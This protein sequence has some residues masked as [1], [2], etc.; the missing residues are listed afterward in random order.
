MC[1]HERRQKEMRFHEIVAEKKTQRV[2][3]VYHGTSSKNVRNILKLG[4]VANPKNKTYDGGLESMGG[5]YSTASKTYALDMGAVA[6]EKND[7]EHIALV[8]MQFVTGS[9]G[10]DEDMVG[11]ILKSTLYS[12]EV[13][14]VLD[15]NL[16]LSSWSNSAPRT[17]KMKASG[18]AQDA[19]HKFTDNNLGQVNK[20]TEEYLKEYIFAVLTDGA[21]IYSSDPTK[22][23]ELFSPFSVTKFGHRD[24][25]L[26]ALDSM[27]ANADNSSDDFFMGDEGPANFRITRDVKFKGKTRITSIDLY[28]KNHEFVKNVFKGK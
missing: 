17:L 11:E 28:D 15:Y 21:K 19:I 25:L 5:V 20:M 16:R 27:K 13:E 4:L 12:D 22:A 3:T 6:S 2:V 1:Q 8:T 23:I 7:S 18:F 9:A 10:I 26:K 24:L 14:E